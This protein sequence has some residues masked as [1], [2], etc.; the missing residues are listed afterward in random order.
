MTQYKETTVPTLNQLRKTRKLGIYDSVYGNYSYNPVSMKGK[1]GN[2]ALLTQ[3]KETI[4]IN[5][6]KSQFV[7]KFKAYIKC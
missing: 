5:L 6:N 2:L 1:K 7:R 3:Y 4:L